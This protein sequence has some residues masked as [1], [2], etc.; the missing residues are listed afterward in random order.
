MRTTLTLDDELARRLKETAART[1]RSF[2]EV[3]DAT[4]RR[5][6]RQPATPPRKY[7][8][9]PV[10]LGGVV[11]GIDLDKALRVAE[12]LEDEALARKLELRK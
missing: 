2:K 8:V 6:L 5:G 1:G 4:L 9:R 12:A 10:S 11:E 3:V 7:R